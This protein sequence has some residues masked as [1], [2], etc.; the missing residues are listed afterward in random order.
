MNALSGEINRIV[1]KTF[2]NGKTV[3]VWYDED[4]ALSEI[5]SQAISRDI[6]LIKWDGSYL[7]I[8]KI[9][10]TEDPELERKWLVY[11]P[12]SARNLSWLK[13]YETIIG[14]KFE[15]TLKK[16]LAD[17]FDLE[18]DAELSQL[19]AGQTGKLLTIH[20]EEVMGLARPPIVK[21]QIVRALLA[22]LFGLGVNFT[23]GRA[24]LEYI[25]FPEKYRGELSQLGLQKVFA[26]MIRT[27]L[28]LS[29]LPLSES[30]DVSKLAAGILLSE[31]VLRSKGMGA[32]E[33]AHLLPSES[34][35]ERWVQLADEWRNDSRLADKFKTW[36]ETLA[37]Q[38]DVRGKL[39]GFQVASVMSFAV[40][41]EILLDEIYS[42]LDSGDLQD[43]I[44]Q[45]N[46]ILAVA[47]ARSE[48][49]WADSLPGKNWKSIGLAVRLLLGC[50]DSLESLHSTRSKDL[51][52][53]ITS[54]LAG[55]GWWLLDRIY[56]ELLSEGP[57]NDEKIK[58]V[59]IEPANVMYAEWLNQLNLDFSE[60]VSA[61]SRWPPKNVMAQTDFWDAVVRRS[62][63]DKLAIFL[64]DALRYDLLK[65]L[66]DR[67]A[68][69]GAEVTTA[70]MIASIPSVTE[71]GMASLLPRE[72]KLLGLGVQDQQLKVSIDNYSVSSKS[73][74]Q[75]WLESQLRAD[76][77]ITDLS[78][79]E[80]QGS[81]DLRR[82]V[83]KTRYLVVTH[84]DIDRAGEFKPE[85]TIAFF[86]GIVRTLAS[87]VLKLHGAGVQKIVI[88]TDHGFLFYPDSWKVRLIDG[89]PS[90]P[91]LAKGRRYVVGKSPMLG[92]LIDFPISSTG[93]V[94][95]GDVAI[96]RGLSML[97]MRGEPPRYVHGG[98]SPQEVCIAYL[99]S[100]YK[101]AGRVKVA[102]QV[103][104]TIA[105]KIFFVGISPVEPAPERAA[106]IKV[107]GTFEGETVVE[108]G[109]VR[110]HAEPIKI[111]L[112]LARIV[113]CVE[114]QL[115]DAETEEILDSKTVRVQL[116][117]YDDLL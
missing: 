94:G 59:F 74:R 63:E 24:I 104:D 27:E 30:V 69:S 26:E 114:F 113:P 48:T 62:A 100:V 5:L 66:A 22:S 68:S 112:V 21:Q 61:I 14:C 47:E 111:R 81:D 13:D 9:I 80:K 85:I 70:P 29:S 34:M 87:A 93:F 78:N 86:G 8:R 116:S 101:K 76:V 33:Y 41:D 106:I 92:E 28:G 107:R 73:E 84:G 75:K 54:Y 43:L 56:V 25:S 64:V 39:V 18:L 77:L 49:T 102:L 17:H 16:L 36:S 90:V 71:V 10:E 50:K 53:Q 117:G 32:K 65:E 12:E 55:E 67:L 89:I 40:V 42:R 38:Y 11:V 79:V 37:T 109:S 103:T 99:V 72:G 108:S 35:R 7:R 115:I 96:P 83:E 95:E 23:V 105:S 60:C 46:T 4:G 19:L 52:G 58:R 20:W 51:N 3:L 82:L 2:G 31:L 15:Y 91:G 45:G 57:M 1:D 110:I 6:S 88:T 97:S 98:A 44:A